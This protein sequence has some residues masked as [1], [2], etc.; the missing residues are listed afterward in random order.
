[1]QVKVFHNVD[2]FQLQGILEGWIAANSP[3]RVHGIAQSSNSPNT[4][5]VTLL[6]SITGP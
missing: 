2:V 6:Y 3:M 5:T 4:V 1:M